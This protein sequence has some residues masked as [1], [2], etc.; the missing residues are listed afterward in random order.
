MTGDQRNGIALAQVEAFGA[1]TVQRGDGRGDQRRAGRDRGGRIGGRGKAAARAHEAGKDARRANFGGETEFEA[2][3]FHRVVIVIDA[4]GV[5]DFGIERKVVRAVA[6]FQQRIDVENQG[7]FSG[8]V[9]ADEG[10]EIGDVRLVIERGERGFAVVGG[11]AA[12]RDGQGQSQTQASVGEQTRHANPPR[13]NKWVKRLLRRS[14]R[15]ERDGFLVYCAE[16]GGLDAGLRK[17]KAAL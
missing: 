17:N 8:V 10:E 12:G 1:G 3:I 2:Q 14:P 4:D 5:D 7:G 9:I 13:R 16:A 11:L 6:G 15:P